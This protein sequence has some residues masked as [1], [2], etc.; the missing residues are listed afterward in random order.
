[1]T[2][3]IPAIIENGLI[4]PLA[5]IPFADQALVQVTIS[6]QVVETNHTPNQFMAAAGMMPWVD[7]P[8]AQDILFSD[9]NSQWEQP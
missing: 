1:M 3:Q 5:A 4:K 9:S 2:I 6:A 8:Q 7:D